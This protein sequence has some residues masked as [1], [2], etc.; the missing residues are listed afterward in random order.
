M[1]RVAVYGFLA[2]AF[3][4]L[5]YFLGYAKAELKHA[6][7]VGEMAKA[8]LG[9]VV[10]TNTVYG[11][12]DNKLIAG[13][14]EELDAQRIEYVRL[15]RE[16]VSLRGTVASMQHHADAGNFAL[17]SALGQ[18]QACDNASSER[19]QNAERVLA[20]WESETLEW[21]EGGDRELIKYRRFWQAQQE[22]AKAVIQ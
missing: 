22:K 10:R 5:S 9:L 2:A 21:L 1:T 8:R 19:L 16:A 18:L 13:M 3:F 6:E 20:E 14:E 12:I 7:Y 17:A 11:E 15:H 4:G